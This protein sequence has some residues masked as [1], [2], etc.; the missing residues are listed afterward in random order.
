MA[1]NIM[2]YKAHLIAQGFSQ[3]SGIDYNNIYVPVAKL[4]SMHTIIMMANCLSIEMH[5]INIKGAYLNGELNENEVL[6]MQHPPSY[7]DS[8]ASMCILHLMK[9][10]YGLK[11]SGCCWYQKLSSIF[12]SLGFK[13]CAIDQAIYFKVIKLKGELI[14][15][16]MHIDNCMIVTS[17]I[18]LIEEL[19][20]GLYMHVE[21]T[22]LGELHWM[23]S[24]EV[25]CDCAGYTMHLS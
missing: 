9:M 1:G 8:N 11:Q 5:Q 16:V 4:V 25:K 23:L 3:I 17:T 7:K 12:V 6:Y 2:H 15:V 10:L 24:I 13:Q 18:C 22:D 21:V 20:A 19:K 14:I